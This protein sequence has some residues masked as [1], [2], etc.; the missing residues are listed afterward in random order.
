M[1]YMCSSVC[2]RDNYPFAACG[3]SILNVALGVPG[4]HESKV[5]ISYGLFQTIKLTNHILLPKHITD[6]RFL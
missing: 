3:L 2:F 6:E 4:L 1:G 5:D